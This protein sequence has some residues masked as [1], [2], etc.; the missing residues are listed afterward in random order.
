[1]SLTLS[2]DGQSVLTSERGRDVDV[3]KAQL[4]TR[5][6]VQARQAAQLVSQA[7]VLM[8]KVPPPRHPLTHAG[9]AF[10]VDQSGS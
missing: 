1:M 7:G 3:A 10:T 2:L 5:P 6:L 9:L 4:L 8:V